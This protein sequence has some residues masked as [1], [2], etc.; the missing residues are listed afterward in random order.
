MTS[1][2][3]SSCAAASLYRRF[4]AITCN[5]SMADT[6]TISI[7][8]CSKSYFVV[9]YMLAKDEKVIS[10]FLTEKQTQHSQT[11]EGRDGGCYMLLCR[12]QFF[13]I[14]AYFLN[15]CFTLLSFSF[16][17]SDLIHK[18][19]QQTQGITEILSEYFMETKWLL[20]MAIKKQ[21]LNANKQ[22]MLRDLDS[23]C[24]CSQILLC[25]GSR[26]TLDMK[27][28]QHYQI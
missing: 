3:T 10:S 17:F 24:S 11:M 1:L 20:K 4:E 19:L 7:S 23:T 9:F 8:Y 5:C 13:N 12:I 15:H 22:C 27:G 28:C 26:I 25:F 18:F 16:N 2:Q 21:F 14:A 6:V